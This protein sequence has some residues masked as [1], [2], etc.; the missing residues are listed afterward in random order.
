MHESQLRVFWCNIAS[1]QSSFN[2]KIRRTI[3]YPLPM[4]RH[5]GNSAS[6]ARHM[7]TITVRCRAS[8]QKLTVNV[9]SV[10][11]PGQ[12][13]GW[14]CGIHQVSLRGAEWASNS[15]LPPRC[16]VQP[17]LVLPTVGE[18]GRGKILIRQTVL[19]RNTMWRGTVSNVTHWETWNIQRY[20]RTSVPTTYLSRILYVDDLRS[21]HLRDLP[22]M[23]MGKYS[24]ASYFRETH[25]ISPFLSVS[26]YFRLSLMTQVQN[27][28]SDLYQCHS[29][30]SAV[31][32]TLFA[33]NSW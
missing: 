26:L 32:N 18:P 11:G 13:R 9:R 7:F 10:S 23:S 19:E 14:K 12:A 24:N 27:L 8:P 28:I 3:F 1:L 22:S 6:T 15:S 2:Q 20:I 16:G 30:S 17:S 29:R 5:G 31:A 4:K 33:N 25:D 21:G